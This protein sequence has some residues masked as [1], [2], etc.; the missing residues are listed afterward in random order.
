MFSP[1]ICVWGDL[2]AVGSTPGWCLGE[3][4]REIEGTGDHG[5]SA[6]VVAR[7]LG[8]MPVAIKFNAVLVGIAEVEGFAY[9]MVGGAVEVDAGLQQ[10]TEGV[11]E[12]G[13]AG[14]E[15]G[16]V[17]EAGRAGGGWGPARAF[18]NIEAD[19]MMVSAG[20]N[21]SRLGSMALHKLKTE[22]ARV[23]GEGAV[24]IGDLQMDVADAGGG[25]NGNRHGEKIGKR[26]GLAN[27][28]GGLTAG[29]GRAAFAEMSYTDD[30]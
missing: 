18:P 14:V 16:G 4:R 30:R 1:E 23:E 11:G 5:E 13:A 19:M 3:K 21:E 28:P 29:A 12:F 15:D 7:P 17:I 6:T 9:A 10:A 25:M 8:G 24:E 20:G 2:V 22:N 27:R 26:P